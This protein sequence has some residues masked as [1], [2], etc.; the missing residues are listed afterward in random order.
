VI[1]ALRT[2]TQTILIGETGVRERRPEDYLVKA[3]V[4][5]DDVDYFSQSD[6]LYDLAGQ[7]VAYYRSQGHSEDELHQILSAHGGELRR[8]IHAQMAEHAWEEASGGYDV[9]VSRGFTE[10]RACHY[11]AAAGQP[12][13]DVRETI[14]D[15]GGIKRMLFGGFKR[16]LYPLQKFHS[17]T[18]RRFALLLE[19]DALKWFKPAKGQFQIYYRKGNEQPEYVPDFVAETDDSIL[20]VETKARTDLTSPEVHAKARAAARW[21]RDASE[22][23]ARLNGKGWSYVLV[24]HDEVT[25]DKRLH[26]YVHFRVLSGD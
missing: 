25:E 26:D 17:D 14:D 15:R 8:L 9:K 18:E 16:C 3:L 19:R 24:P 2:S 1:Q 21:C 12:I 20:M 11:T 5:F 22:Y 10:L 13:R 4:D 6:L 7:A 23:T